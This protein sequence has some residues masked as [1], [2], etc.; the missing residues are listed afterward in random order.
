MADSAK[1]SRPRFP[2]GAAAKPPLNARGLRVEFAQNCCTVIAVQFP[3]VL[4]YPQTPD[5]VQCG[6]QAHKDD[7]HTGCCN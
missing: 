7:L 3:T 1:I 2:W 6:V 4:A 5:A